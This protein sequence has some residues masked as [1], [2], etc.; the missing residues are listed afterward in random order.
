MLLFTI[1][2]LLGCNQLKLVVE[3]QW[4]INEGEVLALQ[5][6]LLVLL[7]NSGQVSALVSVDRH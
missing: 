1:Q 3:L 5:G 6:Q 7:F 2:M 4:M